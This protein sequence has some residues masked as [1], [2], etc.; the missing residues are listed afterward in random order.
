MRVA[1]IAP[2]FQA[3]ALISPSHQRLCSWPLLVTLQSSRHCPGFSSNTFVSRV[4]TL[5]RYPHPG[6]SRAEYREVVTRSVQPHCPYQRPPPECECREDSGH[7]HTAAGRDMSGDQFNLKTD[8]SISNRQ[9]MAFPASTG[10]KE[11]NYGSFGNS[12]PRTGA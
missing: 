7:P 12:T 3:G 4:L 1:W 6:T 11:T 9:K 8:K 5:T 10:C 2:S